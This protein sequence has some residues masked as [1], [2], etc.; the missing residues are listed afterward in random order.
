MSEQSIRAELLADVGFI[1]LRG[2]PEDN[3]FR[4]AAEKALGQSLPVEPNTIATGDQSLFWLGP[5]EWL[6]VASAAAIENLLSGLADAMAEIH[7]A[8][9]DVSGGNTAIR[10]VGSDT[11]RLFAKGCTLDFHPDVFGPGRFAQS[12]L[13]KAS[14]L[15]GLLDDAPTFELIVRR[16]FAGYV[17]NWLRHAGREFGIEF[18]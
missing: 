11:R 3:R 9:N 4:N 18:A 14:V 8:V 17:V 6:I 2:N 7:S 16:S 5:D 10:L 15:V 12:G 1:N 13:G